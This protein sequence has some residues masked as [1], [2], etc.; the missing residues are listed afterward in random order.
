LGRAESFERLGVVGKGLESLGI[1]Y[2]ETDFALIEHIQAWHN[3][4]NFIGSILGVNDLLLET[5]LVGVV[6]NEVGRKSVVKER[7]LVFEDYFDFV[8]L[9]FVQVLLVEEDPVVV[10]CDLLGSEHFTVHAQVLDRGSVIIE[11]KIPAI[12]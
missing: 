3:S 8:Y 7:V 11:L 12:R 6:E 4:F 5:V 10:V 9:F 1:N 2:L